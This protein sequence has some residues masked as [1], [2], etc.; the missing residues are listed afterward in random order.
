[1]N[2]KGR[3]LSGEQV[4]AIRQRAREGTIINDIAKQFGLKVRATR[5]IL[6]GTAWSWIK[7][8]AGAGPVKY[9][10]N[11]N[12]KPHKKSVRPVCPHCSGFIEVDSNDHKGI[13][14]QCEGCFRT[15]PAL[16]TPQERSRA[17]VLSTTPQ[18]E[19]AAKAIISGP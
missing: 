1:M 18:A 2:T 19:P 9:A 14:L 8:P 15:W 6:N 4:V 3:K 10:T 13:F 17:A 5:R 12:T 7:D 16:V 11:T